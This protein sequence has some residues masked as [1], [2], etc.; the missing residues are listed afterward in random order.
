MFGSDSLNDKPEKGTQPYGGW[1]I[2]FNRFVWRGF[3][4][5]MGPLIVWLEKLFP[6]RAL[7]AR[8]AGWAAKTM[9]PLLGVRIEV[10]GLEKLNPRQAYMFCPNHRSHYDV[11]ALLA[12]LPGAR[13]AGKKELWNEPAIGAAIRALGM[14]PIDR[15]NPA[16]AREALDE[17][18]RRLGRSVSV[19]IFPEGTRAPKGE[20]LEF[21]SG[22]FV[23]A[24][25]AQVPVVPVAVH[26]TANV[27]PA[28]GYLSILGGRVVVEILDPIDTTGMSIE[29][30]NVIKD[31]ARKALVEALRPEDGGVAERRD[32]GS[33]RRRALGV[34]VRAASE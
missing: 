13:F 32:L 9:S 34:H 25:Q 33:F 22:A 17:A 7:G 24:I 4:F 26:N 3:I 5:T 16:A 6:N 20:M 18:R 14:I 27:M 15:D 23:F 30:R 29:D 19:I 10:R 8:L 1:R 31:Q 21:K 12:Y 11:A 2:S 28:R